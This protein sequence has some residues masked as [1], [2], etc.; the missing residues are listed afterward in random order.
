M[1]YTFLPHT[2]SHTHR[3]LTTLI[4][5]GKQVTSNRVRQWKRKEISLAKC[6]S[7]EETS[8]CVGVYL[9]VCVG[10]QLGRGSAT[11]AH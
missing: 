8:V 4:R 10:V 9:S 6:S 11:K 3:R 7:S 5:L 2:H 1:R